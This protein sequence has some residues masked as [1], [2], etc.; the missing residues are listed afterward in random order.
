MQTLADHARALGIELNDTQLAAFETYYREL[1]TWNARVNLT[2]ITERDQVVVKHFLDS[3]SVAPAI[4]R[5]ASSLIDVGS[6]AGFPGAP[7]KIVLPDLRV[8][9]LETTGKKV[10]F[11]NHLIAILNLRDTRAI[12]ARAEDLARDDAHRERYDVVV[13]RAVADL[14]V[15]VEYCLPFA[16]VGGVFIA[17]KGIAVEDEIR[18]AARALKVL[19]G[20]VRAITPVPLPGLEPRHLIVVEKIARTPATFPRRA[21]LPARQPLTN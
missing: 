6:G 11:L 13:A 5:D 17:Q 14:A 7:L 1:V 20:R 15:L 16:R 8:T 18:H 10:A 2:A 3:I 21:G 12:Q 4:P 19:G 9:L